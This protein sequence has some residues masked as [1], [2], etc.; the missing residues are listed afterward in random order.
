MANMKQAKMIY[1]SESTIATYSLVEILPGIFLVHCPD[2]YELGMLFARVQEY[3]ESPFDDIRGKDFCLFEYMNLYRKRQGRKSF[4]YPLD[5]G[6]YNVPSESFE[7]CLRGLSKVQYP[8]PYDTELMTILHQ[9]RAVL[10]SGKFYLLG[11]S[12]LIGTAFDHEIAHALF[13][14]SHLYRDEM[15]L[16]VKYG[17]SNTV[18]NKLKE[19]LIYEGYTDSVVIDEIQAYLATDPFIFEGI[20]GVKTLHTKF[21]K[22]FKTFKGYEKSDKD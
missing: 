4:T 13:N 18:F 20:R 5:W 12:E 8:T 7:L 17:I 1:K 10:P 14:L 19:K 21:S 6:G 22:I 16:L 11:I 2:E 9:I 15:T 3:Y